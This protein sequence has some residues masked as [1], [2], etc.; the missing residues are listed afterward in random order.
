MYGTCVLWRTLINFG[1]WNIVLGE[2]QRGR[3]VYSTDFHNH[4]S[5]LQY[6]LIWVS[7]DA[8]LRLSLHSI[9]R[10]SLYFV[11]SFC[12]SFPLTDLSSSSQPPSIYKMLFLQLHLALDF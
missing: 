7:N 8:E 1:V 11:L 6:N 5:A 9:S 10:A 12:S 4:H 2:G 3:V